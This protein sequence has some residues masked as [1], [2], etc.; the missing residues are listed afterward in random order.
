MTP[1][2]Q[3]PVSS[4]VYSADVNACGATPPNEASPPQHHDVQNFV[5]RRWIKIKA[6]YFAP[7]LLFIA[8]VTSYTAQHE[9]S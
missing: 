1:V 8:Y 5:V 7:G 6:S 4:R 9:W 3:E 2:R